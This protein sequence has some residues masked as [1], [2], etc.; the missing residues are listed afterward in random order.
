MLSLFGHPAGVKQ[1]QARYSE[2]ASADK[3]REIFS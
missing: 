2:S 1:S 3:L